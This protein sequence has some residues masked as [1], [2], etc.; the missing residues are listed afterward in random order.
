MDNEKIDMN[1]KKNNRPLLAHVCI[2]MACVFWG[3]M[4][5]LGKD[6]MMNGVDGICMVSF[7][8]IGGAAL[9]WLTSLFVKKE[10]VPWRDRLLLALAGLFGLVFNQCC[11]TIGLN[12]TSPINASIVTTSM[13]IFAMLL[14]AVILHEPIT[15]KKAVGV[16]MGCCGAVTLI[17][18][19]ATTKGGQAGDLRG[20]LLCMAAQLSY[21]LYLSLFNHLVR[22]YHPITVNK[23]MF[24]WAVVEIL[25]FTTPHLMAN[26]WQ[27]VS[28]TTWWETGFV[29]FFGTY[30]SYLLMMVAISTLRP[31]VVSTYNYMQPVTAVVVSVLTGMAVFKPSQALAMLL[32]FAGVALVTKSKSKHDMQKAD[33][34]SSH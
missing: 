27:S 6:A 1:V 30:V 8:V 11:F 33:E 21:A 14:A 25:P 17:L 19:S 12:I 23:W 32:V 29:V 28:L 15:G 34:A 9:F 5:P 18:T 26:A 22:K 3:L 7:R 13:P 16:M 10:R 2:L 4:S 31:T 20:D 24:L